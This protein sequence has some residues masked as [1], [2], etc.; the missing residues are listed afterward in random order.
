MALGTL[1][2][3]FA[4]LLKH[5]PAIVKAVR[6][7]VALVKQIRKDVNPDSVLRSS[8]IDQ[9]AHVNV[10]IDIIARQ[11][12]QSFVP[13]PVRSVA[14][15]P[16]WQK[17]T[18]EYLNEFNRNV[19][20][21]QFVDNM[22][23]LTLLYPPSNPG[24]AKSIGDVIGFNDSYIRN[25]IT[26][27]TNDAVKASAEEAYNAIVAFINTYGTAFTDWEGSFDNS[28]GGLSDSTDEY[29]T[30]VS[31]DYYV[32]ENYDTMINSAI[33]AYYRASPHQCVSNT[34]SLF[35][36]NPQR[37]TQYATDDLY[38][39]TELAILRD[40]DSAG[41]GVSGQMD[42]TD[43]QIVAVGELS[44]ANLTDVISYLPATG[45]HMTATPFNV[46]GLT[47]EVLWTRFKD[48][49]K[50]PV[51][52]PLMRRTFRTRL[53][54][55]DVNPRDPTTTLDSRKVTFA[56][57]PKPD[58][59]AWRS[60][61]RIRANCDSARLHIFSR[62]PDV[63][64]PATDPIRYVA[65]DYGVMKMDALASETDGA[66]KVVDLEYI[67]ENYHESWATSQPY[68]EVFCV[69][70]T[71]TD[72]LGSIVDATN[73]SKFNI[74]I[75]PVTVSA[76]VKPKP[77][78]ATEL[79]YRMFNSGY[80]TNITSGEATFFD[81]LGAL[82]VPT[83]DD[84][85]FSLNAIWLQR[86]AINGVDLNYC[87]RW[88]AEVATRL[89]VD[90]NAKYSVLGSDLSHLANTQLWLLNTGPFADDQHVPLPV[91]V[92]KRILHYLYTDL[93][94]A[95]AYLSQSS[96]AEVSVALVRGESD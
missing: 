28:A 58:L 59:Y 86:L 29:M 27:E 60:T 65:R 70:T 42:G 36:P 56:D 6:G 73:F 76:V 34:G 1:I 48:A 23:R 19:F 95:K 43:A 8:V 40:K 5:G 85:N 38:I 49:L 31:E 37:F 61:V 41:I 16:A 57:V 77:V 3:A 81:F 84:P 25:K 87:L 47:H 9:I 13:P 51:K 88:I 2:A 54:K 21:P 12:G 50:D 80:E 91:S 30:S 22:A 46:C 55:Y 11:S 53:E 4:S 62:A 89:G 96:V 90:V 67:Y 52:S 93:T 69:L 66:C 14:D 32:K 26:A 68:I 20:Q 82:I 94:C 44:G 63:T 15:Y 71:D 35:L 79:S 92:R 17:S 18:T 33:T 83:G 24:S 10:F 78:P 74:Q 39:E 72:T 7:M 64:I 75:E 45:F